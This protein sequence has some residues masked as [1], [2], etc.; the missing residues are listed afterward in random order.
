MKMA[1]FQTNERSEERS[2]S[3]A[4]EYSKSFYASDDDGL[5]DEI[6]D[7]Q[8]KEEP[9]DDL[10]PEEIQEQRTSR[11]KTIFTASSFISIVAG[12]V[13]ILLLLALLFSMIHFLM[14]DF[15]RNILLLQ[16]KL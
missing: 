2:V 7:S 12:T 14:S 1:Y 15:S 5:D 8:E 9:E 6:W 13:V 4:E 16:T 3:S 11:L 10:T